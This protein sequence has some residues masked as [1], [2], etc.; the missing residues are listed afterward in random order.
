MKL[1]LKK[2]NRNHLLMKFGT[3]ATTTRWVSNGAREEKK[4]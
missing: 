3:V 4:E 2:E 1:I